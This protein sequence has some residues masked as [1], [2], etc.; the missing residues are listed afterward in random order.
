MLR[1]NRI[2]RLTLIALALAS[3]TTPAAHAEPVAADAVLDVPEAALAD[4]GAAA[5]LSE[6]AAAAD[7]ELDALLDVGTPAAAARRRRVSSGAATP[8]WA[9]HT[10]T[11]IPSAGRTCAP[12]ES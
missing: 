9:W 4:E 5:D 7:A 11:A 8:S 2:H 10:P 3:L 6:D 12:A 1:L